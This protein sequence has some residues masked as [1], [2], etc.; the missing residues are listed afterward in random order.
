MNRAYG[1]PY[2]NHAFEDVLLMRSARK[3][4]LPFRS[5]MVVYLKA[6]SDLNMDMKTMNTW[7]HRFVI[8]DEDKDGFITL[9]DFARFLQISAS[10]DGGHLKDVFNATKL[11]EGKLGFRHYLY[12]IVGKAQP[13]LQDANLMQTL[14]SVGLYQLHVNILHLAPIHVYNI[15]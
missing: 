6:N 5:G 8:M 3:A 11:E 13:L 12:G 4:G 2:T 9:E 7:L 14:F 10:D 1:V 15:M